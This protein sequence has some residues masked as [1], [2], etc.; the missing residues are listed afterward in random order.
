[1][2]VSVATAV[3][4]LPLQSCTATAACNHQNRSSQPPQS[5]LFWCNTNICPTA[6]CTWAAKNGGVVT[7]GILR[8]C[9]QACTALA[10]LQRHKRSRLLVTLQ[11]C[12][13]L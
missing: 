11:L 9:G 4:Q 5:L 3:S 12:L 2:N 6:C 13:T 1:M 7:A 8:S 10:H